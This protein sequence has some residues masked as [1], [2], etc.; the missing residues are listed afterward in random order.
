MSNLPGFTA[1]QSLCTPSNYYGGF[2][3]ANQSMTNKG[4]FVSPAALPL[5]S[6]TTDECLAM[7]LCAYV[8]PR[9]RVTCGKCP[10]QVWGVALS[11]TLIALDQWGASVA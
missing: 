5:L 9:G 10:G 2:L 6:T 3:R 11:S 7:G 4:T 8:S 1:E